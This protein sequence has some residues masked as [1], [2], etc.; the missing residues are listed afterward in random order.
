MMTSSFKCALKAPDSCGCREAWLPQR[1][2]D[3]G[4]LLEGQVVRRRRQ[5]LL[6]IFTTLSPEKHELA[7]LLSASSCRV[8]SMD[9]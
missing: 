6:S 2:G 1:G 9:Q 7:Q 5:K 3:G 8:V 4:T